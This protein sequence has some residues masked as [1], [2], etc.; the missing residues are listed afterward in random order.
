MAETSATETNQVLAVISNMATAGTT[1]T[2]MT[3]VA[4]VSMT[5]EVATD[6]TMT[7]VVTVDTK[8]IDG[9]GTDILRISVKT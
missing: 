1:T 4:T 8:R 3:G 9:D 6:I 2:R 7:G 5:A